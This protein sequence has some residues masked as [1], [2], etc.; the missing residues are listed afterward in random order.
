MKA[1]IASMIIG[2]VLIAHYILILCTIEL[3]KKSIFEKIMIGIIVT[4]LLITTLNYMGGIAF[5]IS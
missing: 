2:L 4:I 5:Y 3:S 1:I